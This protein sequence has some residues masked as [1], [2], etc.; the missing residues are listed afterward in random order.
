MGDQIAAV[1]VQQGMS[2]LGSW[3][4]GHQWVGSEHRERIRAPK[5]T[6]RNSEI[7][8]DLGGPGERNAFTKAAPRIA[9]KTVEAPGRGEAADWYET[10]NAVHV[11]F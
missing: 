4:T 9:T 5:E 8:Y 11:S 3:I 1:V 2:T 6:L 10:A 7:K